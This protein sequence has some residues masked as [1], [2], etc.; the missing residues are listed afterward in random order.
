MS[1]I[2][3]QTIGGEGR[4]ATIN[5]LVEL[6]GYTGDLDPYSETYKAAGITSYDRALSA[7]QLVVLMAIA[8]LSDVASFDTEAI[9]QLY[10]NCEQD[11]DNAAIEVSNGNL[12]DTIQ[13]RCPIE[14]VKKADATIT[15]QLSECRFW[16][17]GSA[18]DTY[19][20]CKIVLSKPAPDYLEISV[21]Y[22]NTLSSL[23][24]TIYVY[25]NKGESEVTYTEGGHWQDKGY[26]RI[27]AIL[28]WDGNQTN[29]Q[30]DG[31]A[32]SLGKFERDI[33][34]G[35]PYVDNNLKP[36]VVFTYPVKSDITVKISWDEED[37]YG[38]LMCG[39]WTS[40]VVKEGET[41]AQGTAGWSCGGVSVGNAQIECTPYEDDY[42]TYE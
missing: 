27:T 16:Y 33:N 36:K 39:N 24:N 21:D 40:V 29:V 4:L 13:R 8:W 5:N 37:S 14:A 26:A 11:F 20:E 35:Y 18:D 23:N 22:G 17:D 3:T 34:V 6:T 30:P 10:P 38:S 15:A 28:D 42:F 25:I 2:V 12:S 32:L 1:K 9:A 19:C 7:K 41:T 31:K